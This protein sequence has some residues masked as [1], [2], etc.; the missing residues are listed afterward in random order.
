MGEAGNADR[1]AEIV[2]RKHTGGGREGDVAMVV[3]G[4]LGRS[5]ELHAGIEK[6]HRTG[7]DAEVLRGTGFGVAADAAAHVADLEAAAVSTPSSSGRGMATPSSGLKN[8]LA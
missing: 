2:P 5:G 6:I 4:K 7:P 1:R 3:G 8:Q